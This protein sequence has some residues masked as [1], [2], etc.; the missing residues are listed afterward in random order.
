MGTNYY[1]RP[2]QVTQLPHDKLW[3][4]PP[5]QLH[6]G[7]SSYCWTFALHVY[8]R[9]DTRPHDLASW[10]VL[11]DDP[12]CIIVDEYNRQISRREMLNIILD[13]DYGHRQIVDGCSC[14]GWGDGS[15]DLCI[16]HENRW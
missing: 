11:F 10:R 2:A 8:P 16:G 7:K 12:Q 14:I 15:Y 1:L 5:P 9:S 3:E 13:R 6:I 4:Q